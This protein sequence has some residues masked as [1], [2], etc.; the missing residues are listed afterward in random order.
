MTLRLLPPLLG[1][2]WEVRGAPVRPLGLVPFAA[3]GSPLTKTLGQSVTT[4]TST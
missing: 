2:P 1:F 3:V 4:K